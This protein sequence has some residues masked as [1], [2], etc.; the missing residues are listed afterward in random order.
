MGDACT[1]VVLQRPVG[2]PLRGSMHP[3]TERLCCASDAKLEAVVTGQQAQL[4]KLTDLGCLQMKRWRACR[5]LQ[6]RSCQMQL[7]RCSAIQISSPS[8]LGMK[9]KSR[10][11]RRS[12]A[13]APRMMKAH[14]KRARRSEAL[15]R[16]H[17]G[18]RT[19]RDHSQDRH[20]KSAVQSI[21]PPALGLLE[22]RPCCCEGGLSLILILQLLQVRLKY[23]WPTRTSAS[24]VDCQYLDHFLDLLSS[25]C[26]S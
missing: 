15:V 10:Q 24:G 9:Q 14:P 13:A 11:K 7:L 20:V 12:Q 22:L 19:Q 26:S 6:V 2:R 25:F 16:S 8:T 5:H 17:I 3:L 21:C 4:T 18:S 1:R 23:K